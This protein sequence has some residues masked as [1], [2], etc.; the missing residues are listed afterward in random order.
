MKLSI[1][2][3]SFYYILY[4]QH[5]YAMECVIITLTHDFFLKR[6]DIRT[7]TRWRVFRP[8]NFVRIINSPSRI[9][10][11]K[12][13]DSRRKRDVGTIYRLNDWENK[14]VII[15]NLFQYNNSGIFYMYTHLVDLCLWR[16]FGFRKSEYVPPDMLFT[17]L[18]W[19]KEQQQHGRGIKCQ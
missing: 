1:V 12:K 15:F 9:E 3:L 5:H 6:C 2:S 17:F 8:I 18:P 16:R 19:G 11:N 7:F 10:D 13:V 4:T 14:E